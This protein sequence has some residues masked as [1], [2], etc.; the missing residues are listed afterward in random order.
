MVRKACVWKLQ[1]EWTPLLLQ[2][3]CWWGDDRLFLD[4]IKGLMI[5]SRGMKG[6]GW[7]HASYPIQINEKLPSPRFVVL[8]MDTE[9]WWRYV[10]EEFVIL[11]GRRATCRR[12]REN[13]AGAGR[14]VESGSLDLA[15]P[16]QSPSLTMKHSRHSLSR[17]LVPA[18]P[19]HHS[20]IHPSI[21][22][23]VRT[24]EYLV[25][26]PW[27][28]CGRRQVGWDRRSGA[29]AEH[30]REQ[31]RNTNTPRADTLLASAVSDSATR[32]KT[33][34]CLEMRSGVS[35]IV[36]MST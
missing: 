5:V 18:A 22:P 20:S 21:S 28:K 19:R 24:R 29:A 10:E 13:A 23:G 8:T 17:S 26:S 25:Y 6:K 32:K 9:G 31:R 2:R 12:A 14:S 36:V 11:H 27:G 16:S 3:H 34:H 35:C 30:R 1:K 7:A 33:V 15:S 4:V